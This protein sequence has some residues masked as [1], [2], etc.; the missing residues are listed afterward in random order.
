VGGLGFAVTQDELRDY[1]EQKGFI[2][3]KLRIL[4]DKETG[5]SKGAAFVELET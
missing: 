5:K 4:T 1:F 3:E 2:V